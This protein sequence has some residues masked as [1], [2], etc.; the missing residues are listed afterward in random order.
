MLTKQGEQLKEKVKVQSSSS[1]DSSCALIRWQ[2]SAS[3]ANFLMLAKQ[4]A[5][6]S[7]RSQSVV[8]MAFSRNGTTPL[9]CM[10]IQLNAFFDKW[11]SAKAVVRCTFAFESAI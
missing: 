2:V 6:A 11:K 3:S 1:L 10:V 4:P 7:C 5:A 9:S 8:A